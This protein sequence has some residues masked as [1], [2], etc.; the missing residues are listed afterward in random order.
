MRLYPRLLHSKPNERNNWRFIADNEG[1][2]WSDIDEDISVKNIILGQRTNV[3]ELSQIPDL[4][5]ENW[6]E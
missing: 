2:H 6:L 3:R 4:T 5:W 1:I